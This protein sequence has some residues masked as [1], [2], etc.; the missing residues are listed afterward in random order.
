[1]KISDTT[2]MLMLAMSGGLA[3]WYFKKGPGASKSS[4]VSVPTQGGVPTISGIPQQGGVP[5]TG[6]PADIYSG[7]PPALQP[8]YLSQPTPLS[9]SQPL[10]ISNLPTVTG[11]P[12]DSTLQGGISALFNSL[13][14]ISQ[15]VL[16]QEPSTIPNIGNKAF[17]F[18]SPSGIVPSILNLLGNKA[19]GF[20]SQPGSTYPGASGGSVLPPFTGLNLPAGLNIGN[21]IGGIP[22][23][24]PFASIVF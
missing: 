23:P 15:Q 3:W 13:S 20:S 8:S 4:Q 5:S 2:T 1:M 18:N 22:S 24:N 21:S 10:P 6:G 16:Q 14:Q 12:P 11:Q 7:L 17:G 19:F 9:P